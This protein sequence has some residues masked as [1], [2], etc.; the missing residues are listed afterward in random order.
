MMACDGPIIREFSDEQCVQYCK[1]CSRCKDCYQCDSRQNC[2]EFR[3]VLNLL[4][5]WEMVEKYKEVCCPSYNS[6]KYEAIRSLTQH[7][8]IESVTIKYDYKEEQWKV[9]WTFP[10][11][12]IKTRKTK[13]K[14]TM[15]IIVKKCTKCPFKSYMYEQGFCGDV[16]DLLDGY[17]IIAESGVRKNCPLMNQTVIVKVIKEKEN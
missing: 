3:K 13:G 16:C 4:H 6:A 11:P 1:T 14:N 8:R 12:Q 7:D 9:S 5:Y 15:V 17:A 2:R 10:K